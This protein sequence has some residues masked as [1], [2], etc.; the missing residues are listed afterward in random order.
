[1]YEYGVYFRHCQ[2]PT[3]KVSDMRVQRRERSF[4]QPVTALSHFKFSGRVA[5]LGLW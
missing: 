2:T 1:M 3:Q 5:P 4:S